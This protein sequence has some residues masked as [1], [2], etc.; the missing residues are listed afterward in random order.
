M[1]ASGSSCSVM[2]HVASTDNAAVHLRSHALLPVCFELLRV[3]LAHGSPMTKTSCCLQTAGVVA[4]GTLAAQFALGSDL[5]LSVIQPRMNRV[6][7]GRIEGSLLYT[8]AHIARIK[9]QVRS[10]LVHMYPQLT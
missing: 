8:S 3:R 4:L 1:L 9:A 6:I 7:H 5:L 10:Y 2:T